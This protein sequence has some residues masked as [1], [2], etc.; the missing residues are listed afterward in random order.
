MR[1]RKPQCPARFE[2]AMWKHLAKIKIKTF[3][4]NEAVAEITALQNGKPYPFLN[5][6]I[7]SC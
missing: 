5:G 7:N 1:Y 6:G 2:I 4:S 3:Y